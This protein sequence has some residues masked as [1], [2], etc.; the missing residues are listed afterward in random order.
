MEM[1]TSRHGLAE[2]TVHHTGYV[3]KNLETTLDYLEKEYGLIADEPYYFRPDKAWVNGKEAGEYVLKIAMVKTG[4]GS[5]LEFI[6]P[7]EGE[8]IHKQFL[9]SGKCGIQHVCFSVKDYDRWHAF[10][11]DKDADI[12]FEAE[13]ED[14]RFGYRRCFYAEDRLTGTMFEI[15]EEP[16]FRTK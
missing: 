6:E 3:I 7:I 11:K 1:N 8:G 10:F 4:D 5:I 9:D 2:L 13:V 15:K 12:V 16:Y 14:E